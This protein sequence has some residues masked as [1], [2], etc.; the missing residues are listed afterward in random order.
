MAL[1]ISA[2][3]S[4]TIPGVRGDATVSRHER[5]QHRA[6]GIDDSR[7][8]RLSS[9]RKE[10]VAGN[11]DPYAW[12]ANNLH[13]GLADRGQQAQ[14]LRSQTPS[15]LQDRCS[16][17]DVLANVAHMLARRHRS[18]YLDRLAGDVDPFAGNHRVR[19]AGHRC[20]G[21]D[22]DRGTRDDTP[23]R[24]HSG[25]GLV[26]HAQ[27]ES[28]VNSWRRACHLREPRIRPSLPAEIRAHRGG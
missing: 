6:V 28:V 11:H 15:S 27:F 24:R 8:N 7:S 4:G 14:V 16:R 17:A 2:G 1:R 21:H 26:D 19:A 20:P 18:G 3:S 9:G 23:R 13:I 22:P 5:F 12:A 10:L 25:K